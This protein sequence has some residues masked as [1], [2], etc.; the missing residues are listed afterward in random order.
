MTDRELSKLQQ[1]YRSFFLQTLHSYGVES[2]AKL[3]KEKKSEFFKCIKRDWAIVKLSKKQYEREFEA[4]P[5]LLTD[6]PQ[7]ALK[8]CKPQAVCSNHT[9]GNGGATSVEMP[10]QTIKSIPNAEQTDDLRILYTPNNHF[11]Q[12]Q[13]YC[14]PVVKM[15]KQ[16]ASLKL[17]RQG[18]TNQRGYKE[19]EFTDQLK[20]RLVGLEVSDNVHLVIPH[21]GRPYEPDIVLIDKSRNLYID[22]EID[23]PY[24]GFY[25]YPTH[26]IK[27]EQVYK[28][29][30]IRDL[31]FVESG[32]IVIRF[33]E[34]QVHLQSRECIDHIA[35]VVDSLS[36]QQS[37]NKAADCEIERQWDDNQCIQWQKVNYREKY[38][39]IAGFQK[40]HNT[41][42]IE[43]NTAEKDTIE[44]VIER[45]KM[46]NPV[47]SD[48]PVGIDEVSHIYLGANDKTGN[49]EYISVTTLLERFFPFDLRRYVEKKAIEENRTEDEVLVEFLMIRDEAAER[50][51]YLH[52]QIENYLTD[53]SVTS[54]LK[55]F[56]L[57][58]NFFH[59]QIAPRN[60][61]FRY[62][63]KRI[64]STMYN[65]AG[66]I[67]CLYRK[68]DKDEYVMLDWKRSKKLII[69]GYPRKFAYGSALSELN[70]LDN[71]SYY[72]YC[73]Q[74]NIYKYI[75]EREYGMKISSMR[76]VVLHED[77]PDYYMVPVPEMTIETKLIL[78]SLQHKI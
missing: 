28:K 58:L 1:E 3:T 8:R 61:E 74:Q 13:N 36:L 29:D 51:T 6:T 69:D 5:G 4:F 59:S 78:N 66:T 15:P 68:K 45:T 46:F 41:Q 38:L 53:N 18:R 42:E 47:P 71:S 54:D 60:L 25:R 11:E 21:F 2:P 72:K 40:N 37:L 22:V 49:A 76:L 70:H 24:D 12:E 34:K 20:F 23:E 19:K 50:G 32:W 56:E 43:I 77:Y 44:D 30:D 10:R 35:N 26:S 17:P 64:V 63:E 73:L 55:E 33:T 65:V 7:Q 62:A 31:F 16:N 27:F 14:Y 57:F 52:K 48:S 67:D 9:H 39:G 75:V